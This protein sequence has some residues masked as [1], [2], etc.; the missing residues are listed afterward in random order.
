VLVALD[1]PRLWVE[2]SPA[3]LAVR[4]TLLDG[5]MAGLPVVTKG[6]S[7]GPPERL[8]DLIAEAAA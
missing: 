1:D 2:R 8:A 6:G 4:A 3:P 7:T 5:P